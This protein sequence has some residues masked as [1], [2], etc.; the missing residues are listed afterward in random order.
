MDTELS[1]DQSSARVMNSQIDT[2][3]SHGGLY[4][5]HGALIIRSVRAAHKGSYLCNVSNSQGSD[6]SEV[7]VPFT[8]R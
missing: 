4:I 6:T 5:H 1:P 7:R 8:F 3:N 2:G